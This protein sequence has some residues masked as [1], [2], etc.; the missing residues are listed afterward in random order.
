MTHEVSQNV[1]LSSHIMFSV[2]L[3]YVVNKYQVEIQN[4]KLITSFSLLIS[5]LRHPVNV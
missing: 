4:T 2:V 3:I 1:G 5:S